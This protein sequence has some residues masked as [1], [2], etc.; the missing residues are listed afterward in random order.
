MIQRKSLD[1]V[2]SEKT[3]YELGG[4]LSWWNIHKTSMYVHSKVYTIIKKSKLINI[5]LFRGEFDLEGEELAINIQVSRNYRLWLGLEL[6]LQ[7]GF[8]LELGLGL[9]E[10]G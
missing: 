3:K 1:S 7:L 6:C 10:I 4:T 2:A 8:R 5:S 9:E